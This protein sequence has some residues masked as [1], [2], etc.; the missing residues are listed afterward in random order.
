MRAKERL[1]TL[2]LDA[3]GAQDR[4]KFATLWKDEREVE[5]WLFA[6]DNNLCKWN[7]A[8]NR[9][10]NGRVVDALKWARKQLAAAA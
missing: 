10:S 4:V 9:A 7:L 8:Y 2:A 1:A 3:T 5:G 6:I